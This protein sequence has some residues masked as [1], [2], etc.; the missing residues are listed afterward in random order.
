MVLK[1]AHQCSRAVLIFACW[2]TSKNDGELTARPRIT[3]GVAVLGRKS[4]ARSK[5]QSWPYPY[6]L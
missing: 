2:G 5:G 6:L 1:G 3:D 4:D